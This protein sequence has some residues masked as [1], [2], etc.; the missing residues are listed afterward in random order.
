MSRSQN[1]ALL[2]IL[3]PELKILTKCFYLPISKIISTCWDVVIDVERF[4]EITIASTQKSTYDIAIVEHTYF[5]SI[6]CITTK[7]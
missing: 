2:K 5:K 7:L 3:S 6:K 1:P 4:E